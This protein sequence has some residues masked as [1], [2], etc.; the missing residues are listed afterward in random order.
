[1]DNENVAVI[2]IGSSSIRMTIYEIKENSYLIQEELRNPIRL[3]KDTFYNGKINRNTI[4]ESILILKNYKR[5]CNEYNVKRIKAVATTAVREAINVDIF[6]DNIRIF[7]DLEIEILPISKEIEFIYTAIS[8]IGEKQNSISEYWGI[9]K[10][11]AGSIDIM[12]VNDNCIVFSRS[13]QLGMLKLKQMFEKNFSEEESFNI[14]L[15]VMIKHELQNLKRTIPKFKISKLYGFGIEINEL[16]RVL[17]KQEAILTN[18]SRKAIRD[19]CKKI[20][21]YT[22]DE[23]FHKLKVPYDVSDTFFSGTLIFQ[24]ILDFFA[25]NNIFLCNVSLNDGIFKRLFFIKEDKDNYYNQLEKQIKANAINIGRSL[26]FDE[27]HAI[28]VMEL[29][30]KIFDKTQEIHNLSNKEKMYLIVAGIL[31]DIGSSLSYRSHHKHSLYIIKAQELFYFNE[32]EVNIIANVARYHRKSAPKRSHIDYMQLTNKDRM[33]VTKLASILRIADSLD[34]TH[35]QIIENID[36]KIDINKIIMIAYV[37][38]KFFT[39]FFSFKYKKLLFEDFFGMKIY[40]RLTKN[41]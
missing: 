36:I 2:D 22:E 21:N 40:L 35:I 26:F 29:A 27:K 38:H 10:I 5:L 17:D 39:E 33:T 6:L 28:K 9:I 32:N 23:I 31:H 1:M 37:R 11:G 41:E 19:L 3:G 34:N 18:I 12:I 30:V 24:K 20:Q 25:C 4:D 13:M 7:T 15:K 16:S 8:E 14:F